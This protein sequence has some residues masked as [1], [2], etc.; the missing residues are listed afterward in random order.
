[1]TGEAAARREQGQVDDGLLLVKPSNSGSDE[2]IALRSPT[3]Y[4]IRISE[5]PATE[6]PNLS[7]EP[8]YKFKSDTDAADVI[9][10]TQYEPEQQNE[11]LGGALNDRSKSQMEPPSEQ[12]HGSALADGLLPKKLPSVSVKRASFTKDCRNRVAGFESLE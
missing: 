6:Q 2:I 7:S 9:T 4:A 3:P 11:D 1:M 5:T 10:S 12:I 8:P